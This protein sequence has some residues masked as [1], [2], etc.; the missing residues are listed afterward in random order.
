MF[1]KNR[2]GH[3]TVALPSAR[4]IGDHQSAAKIAPK[5]RAAAKKV[6]T[7]GIVLTLSQQA[8]VAAAVT[9]ASGFWY[10]FF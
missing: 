4:P 7:N 6:V 8:Q 5:T 1:E 9:P 2:R 3:R 10:D